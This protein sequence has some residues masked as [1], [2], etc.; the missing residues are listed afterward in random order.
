MPALT[1]VSIIVPG[2]MQY[3]A[4]LGGGLMDKGYVFLT[5]SEFMEEDVIKESRVRS[6]ASARQ[7][8]SDFSGL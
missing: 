4:C 3:A 5:L 1:L 7:A 8:H 2:A 6:P